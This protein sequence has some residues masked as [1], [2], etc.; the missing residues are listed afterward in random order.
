MKDEDIE[1]IFAAGVA[2]GT[3]QT[4]NALGLLPE[5]VTKK[6]AEKIYSK[7]LISLWR[8][9][10]WITAYPAHNDDRGKFYFKKSELEAAS[11]MIDLKNTVIDNRIKNQIT[12]EQN[13][14]YNN[15]RK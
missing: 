11:K 2:T 9:K 3:Y 7:R 1:K 6:Q 15:T 13:F 4:L 10:G 14:L 8:E 5:V 12:Y